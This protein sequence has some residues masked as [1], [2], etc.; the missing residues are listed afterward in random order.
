MLV[1]SYIQREKKKESERSG[2]AERN[3]KFMCKFMCCVIFKQAVLH[4]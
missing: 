2:L 1:Y 3:A 4:L